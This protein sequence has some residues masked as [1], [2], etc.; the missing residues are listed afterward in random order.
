[1]VFDAFGYDSSFDENVAFC[2]MIDIT[3]RVD[4]LIRGGVDN[5]RFTIEMVIE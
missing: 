1:M 3:F 5:K 2:D 4:Q